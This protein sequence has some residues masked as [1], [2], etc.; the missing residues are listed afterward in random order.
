MCSQFHRKMVDISSVP[1]RFILHHDSQ[2]KFV[3]DWIILLA[4]L[5]VAVSVSYSIS[6]QPYDLSVAIKVVVEVVFV[7]G[8]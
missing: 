6:F 3:W 8:E 2:F 4:V 5:F 7:V 1:A